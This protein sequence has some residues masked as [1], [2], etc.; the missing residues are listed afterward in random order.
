MGINATRVYLDSCLVI[1][2]VEQHPQFGP[3]ITH[4]MESHSDLH[5]CISPLVELE[6][7][8]MPIRQSNHGLI[9]RYEMFFQDYVHLEI[10]T[11]IYRNAAELRAHHGLKT[12]DALH[13]ATAKYHA[14]SEFWTND[15][16]LNNVAGNLAVNLFDNSVS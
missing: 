4:A 13:L 14:C 6:C 7:L 12:P 9:D 10:T 15:G 5:F 11:D 1:Y 8:V 3:V 16:R 2:F